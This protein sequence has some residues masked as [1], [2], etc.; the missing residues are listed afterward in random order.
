MNSRKSEEEEFNELKEKLRIG[1]KLVHERLLEEKKR[2]GSKLV[3]ML[4]GK[5]VELT[6]DEYLKL[7][8]EGRF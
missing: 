1:F 2:T 3:T 5:V 4:D 7:K 8:E 6:V